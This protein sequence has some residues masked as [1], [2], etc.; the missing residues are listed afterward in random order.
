MRYGKDVE[1]VSKGIV[2]KYILGTE[3]I[4]QRAYLRIDFKYMLF[5]PEDLRPAVGKR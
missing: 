1:R 4:N 5:F 3:F 2:R